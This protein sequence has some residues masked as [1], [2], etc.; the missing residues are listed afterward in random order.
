M[1]LIVQSLIQGPP[2]ELGRD[3]STLSAEEKRQLALEAR[4]CLQERLNAGIP[5][6][7]EQLFYLA[8]VMGDS[9]KSRSKGHRHWGLLAVLLGTRTLLGAPGHTTSNNYEQEQ[10][11]EV[12]LACSSP[13]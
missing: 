13:D 1:S 5:S 3:T 4:E 6:V 11:V 7:P 10:G 8:H 2:G 9:W 12:P